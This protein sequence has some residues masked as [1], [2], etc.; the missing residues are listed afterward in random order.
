MTVFYVFLV[1]YRKEKWEWIQSIAICVHQA[2]WI[3]CH[4][5][6]C[7]YQNQ[8]SCWGDYHHC[9]FQIFNISV[10]I[11]HLSL[12]CPN[13]GNT[14]SVAFSCRSLKD[15]LLDILSWFNLLHNLVVILHYTAHSVLFIP[16]LLEPKNFNSLLNHSILRLAISWC[17]FW[18]HIA[19]QSLI[20]SLFE[21]LWALM[22]ILAFLV[23]RHS[24]ESRYFFLTCLVVLFNYTVAICMSWI[25]QEFPAIN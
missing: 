22:N 17:L 16:A 15:A 14:L 19:I 25:A 11:H 1:T 23:S 6:G 10:C 8:I 3:W 20:L 9:C 12:M 5:H 7:S 24:G 21:V 2:A 18:G 13:A 4:G